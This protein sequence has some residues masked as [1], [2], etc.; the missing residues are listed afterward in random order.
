MPFAAG[1][2]SWLQQMGTMFMLSL[3]SKCHEGSAVGHL[4]PKLLAAKHLVKHLVRL[5]C[6]VR[7]MQLRQ[8][9]QQGSASC[10]ARAQSGSG[11]I[12]FIPTI[13]VPQKKKGDTSS[14][15]ASAFCK[16]DSSWRCFDLAAELAVMTETPRLLPSQLLPFAV[17]HIAATSSLPPSSNHAL[18]VTSMPDARRS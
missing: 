3:R 8:R 5:L 2:C 6:E 9:P 7:S 4:S 15:A 10:K 1:E 16:P 11:A 14:A 12:T 13:E 17:G 18:Q